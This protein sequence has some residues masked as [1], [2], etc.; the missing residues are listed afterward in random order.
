MITAS[1]RHHRPA[2][3]RGHAPRARREHRGAHSEEVGAG[4]GV[5][6][7]AHALD[8][9]LDLLGVEVA[10]RPDDLPAAIAWTTALPDAVELI[11]LRTRQFAGA[12]LPREASEH[13]RSIAVFDH[14]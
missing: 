13:I 14:P 9:G 8:P 6:R 3:V 2:R 12:S 5:Q 1:G 11:A 7:A 10:A 4:A